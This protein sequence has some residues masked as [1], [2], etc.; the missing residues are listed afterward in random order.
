VRA[1]FASVTA[2]IV[3]LS[4][5][6]DEFMSA[7]NIDSLHGF[8]ASAPR[9]MIRLDPRDVGQARIGHFGFFRAPAEPALWR[10][11]LLPAL[12]VAAR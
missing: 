9:H 5:T 7:R 10:P 3:S 4:F 1:Q 8:Y 2:P 12:A 11:Y 6:D